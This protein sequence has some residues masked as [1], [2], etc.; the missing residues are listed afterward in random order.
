M[1]IAA[2]DLRDGQVYSIVLNHPRTHRYARWNAEHG[3]FV[4]QGTSEDHYVEPDQA[5]ILER[6]D[7]PD[8]WNGLDPI[9]WPSP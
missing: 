2:G 8:G 5:E 9:G 1:S 6:V 4:W 7:P 3:M